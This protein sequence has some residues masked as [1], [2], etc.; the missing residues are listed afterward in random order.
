MNRDPRLLAALSYSVGILS[1][2]LVLVIE[3][4]DAYVR[5]HAVQSVLVFAVIAVVS[6]LLPTVPVIGDWGAVRVVFVLSVVALWA[7]LM[8]KAIQG[9]G[10]RLP[11]LG[12]LAAGLFTS[13]R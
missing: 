13:D 1:A 3:K 8:F 6:L 12:D 10:Y 5:F 4:K 7:F 2:I 11:Y 9:D